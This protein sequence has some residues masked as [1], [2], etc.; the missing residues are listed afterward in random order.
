MAVTIIGNTPTIFRIITGMHSFDNAF[1]NSNKDIGFPMGTV[2]EVAGPTGIG[3]STTVYSLAGMI[4]AELNRN[5]AL[6]DLEGFDQAFLVD[7]LESN[8]FG[9]TLLSITEDDDEKAMDKL[10]AAVKKDYAVGILD[11]VGAISPIAEAEGSLGESNMGRRGRL[12]AQFSRKTMKVFR[13][14]KE[15]KVFF[16]I[17]HLHPIIGGRGMSTPGGETIKYLSSVRMRLKQK[18]MLPDGSYVIEGKITKNRFGYRDRLF[19]LF[20]LA[21][22]GVH[23]GLTCMW[24]GILTGVV[25][26]KTVIKIGDVSYGSL[27][28]IVAKAQEGEVDFFDPFYSLLE[29]K[30]VVYADTESNKESDKTSTD[31]DD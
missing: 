18:E 20:V 1:A 30:E 24:D 7:V 8:G 29:D 3:K 23:K 5:I 16:V 22:K 6:L 11:S 4:G 31:I 28:S 15:P 17:N 14:N 10:V 25:S 26:R 27:K 12:L 13:D 21:G 9:G 2:V 19:Y